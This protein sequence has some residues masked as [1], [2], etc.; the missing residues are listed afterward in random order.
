MMRAWRR[1]HQ[2]LLK[3]ALADAHGAL[4]ERLMKEL[5]TL[6]SGREL[7]A[8]IRAQN[9]GGVDAN[10]RLIACTRSTPLFV[11]FANAP[12]SSQSTTAIPGE[13]PTAF[14]LIRPILDFP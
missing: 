9:W 4:M 2:E 8:S 12:A 10:T 5:G 1:H 6:S 11:D 7:V 14:Q 3:Q 13:R